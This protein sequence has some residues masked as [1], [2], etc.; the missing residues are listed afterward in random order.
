M[1][2]FVIC[3]FWHFRTAYAAKVRSSVFPVVSLGWSTC[4]VAPSTR[5]LDA[6]AFPFLIRRLFN[7]FIFDKFRVKPKYTKSTALTRTDKSWFAMRRKTIILMAIGNQLFLGFTNFTR[8]MSRYLQRRIWS[9]SRRLRTVFKKIGK[10]RPLTRGG[11]AWHL[12]EWQ[13]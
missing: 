5:S 12:G 8:I 2:P 7:S 1:F 10:S 11:R 9:V 3:H 4:A 13:G 6:P